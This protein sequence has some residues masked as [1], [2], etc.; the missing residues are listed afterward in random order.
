MAGLCSCTRMDRSSAPGVMYTAGRGTT[1]NR[2]SSSPAA[3]RHVVSRA[4]GVCTL[5]IEKCRCWKRPA[6]QQL[7]VL[8]SWNHAAPQEALPAGRGGPRHGA[9]VAESCFIRI[10]ITFH[11]HRAVVHYASSASDCTQRAPGRRTLDIVHL[12]ARSEAYKRAL[13]C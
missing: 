7:H 11:V 8:S 1:W 2:C 4:D 5:T 9:R 3:A 12:H 13:A 6:A 10:K